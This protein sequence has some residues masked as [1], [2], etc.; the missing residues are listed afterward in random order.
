[1]KL[2]DGVSVNPE[3]WCNLISNDPAEP[4]FIQIDAVKLPGYEIRD[5]TH[6][7]ISARWQAKRACVAR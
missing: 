7:S 2:P 4:G 6:Q 3:N 1:M 5:F